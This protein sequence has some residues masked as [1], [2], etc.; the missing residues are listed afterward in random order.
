MVFWTYC[1]KLS[2]EAQCQNEKLKV[3]G[4]EISGRSDVGGWNQ[5]KGAS[6]NHKD[7]VQ[8]QTSFQLF[9]LKHSF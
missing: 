3:L 2:G 1:Q 5:Q 8:K 6:K 4:E 7:L 9:E